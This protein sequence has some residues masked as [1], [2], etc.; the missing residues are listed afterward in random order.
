[1]NV[2]ILTKIT[3]NIVMLNYWFE[4]QYCKPAANY[5]NDIGF[6]K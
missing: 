2:Y 6:G 5:A 3:S 4:L 1:M